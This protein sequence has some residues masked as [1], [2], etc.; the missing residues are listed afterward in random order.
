MT[1]TPRQFH[2]GDRITLTD[3]TSPYAG[4]CGVVLF[5]YSPACV[6]GIVVKLDGW[7]RQAVFRKWQIEPIDDSLEAK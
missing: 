5:T 7:D 1:A 6:D 2:I 4:C 3:R